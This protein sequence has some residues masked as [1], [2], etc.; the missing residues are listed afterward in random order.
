[1]PNF[2]VVS[3][4]SIFLAITSKFKFKSLPFSSLPQIFAGNN[5]SDEEAVTVFDPPLF[6]RYLRIHPL[7]WINGIA[8]RLEVLGCDT[9]QVL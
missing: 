8:L 1:M 6:G 7:G 2:P 3:I 4:I 5:D 9:Q